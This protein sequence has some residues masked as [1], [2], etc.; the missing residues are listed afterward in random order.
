MKYIKQIVFITVLGSML[1]CGSD[2][3]QTVNKKEIIAERGPILNALIE[4]KNGQIAK[5][6][7]NTNIYEFSNDVKFPVVVKSNKIS[8]TYIDVDRNKE[9]SWLDLLLIDKK[10]TSCYHN[11][12]PITSWV[13]HGINDCDDNTSKEKMQNKLSNLSKE[14]NVSINELLSLP[15]SQNETI[16]IISNAVYYKYIVFNQKNNDINISTIKDEYEHEISTLEPF[17]TPMAIEKN[18]VIQ[19]L[20]NLINMGYLL[21]SGSQIEELKYNIKNPL[22]QNDAKFKD[23]SYFGIKCS[24]YDYYDDDNDDDD[25][26]C[27][28]FKI[29]KYEIEDNKITTTFSEINN[30]SKTWTYY[31]KDTQMVYVDENQKWEE[32]NLSLKSDNMIKSNI[33]TF[34]LKNAKK[35]LPNTKASVVVHKDDILDISFDATFEENSILYKTKYNKNAHYSIDTNI[36]LRGND[37]NKT[38]VNYCGK[39]NSSMLYITMLDEDENPIKALNFMG[40]W[41]GSDMDCSEA[42]V[43]SKKQIASYKYN[44]TNWEYKKTVGT[45]KYNKIGDK[46]IAIVDLNDSLDEY[47]G[48]IF[49][50]NYGETSFII[51]YNNKVTLGEDVDNVEVEMKLYNEKSIESIKNAIIELMQ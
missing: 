21:F 6:K 47:E 18:V 43:T 40:N 19:Y 29:Y 33:S 13:S 51:K 20:R 16:N 22:N 45:W 31:K 48:Y 5:P 11:V 42:N 14:F 46:Q 50:K 26:G 23:G 41:N 2:N 36:S 4:D 24:R 12:T 10:L 44:G 9:P 7:N 34:I 35:I 8:T 37:I 38:M 1:G 30:V 3:S 32:D 17:L 28:A 49:E 39:K 25:F 27:S 15:S